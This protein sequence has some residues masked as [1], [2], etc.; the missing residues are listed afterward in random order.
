MMGAVRTC[1]EGGKRGY[2]VE[3]QTTPLERAS[4]GPES[5]QAWVKMS[6]RVRNSGPRHRARR[7]GSPGRPLKG[8]EMN[9]PARAIHGEGGW[10]CRD[11]R[12]AV[13]TS[14]SLVAHR[15][16]APRIVTMRGQLLTVQSVP[17]RGLSQ[18]LLNGRAFTRRP[19]SGM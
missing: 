12:D 14:C 3:V 8:V 9:M 7:R 15:D 19:Y 6:M 1:R 16:N 2:P 4:G 13:T 11:T 17:D 5:G 10:G 18:G